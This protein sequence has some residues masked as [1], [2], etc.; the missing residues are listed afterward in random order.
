MKYDVYHQELRVGIIAWFIF[1][2]ALHRSNIHIL[3]MVRN[4]RGV[5]GD[6]HPSLL[7]DPELEETDMF[8]LLNVSLAAAIGVGG[9]AGFGR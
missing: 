3:L 8:N 2:T 7:R 5:N 6:E 4:F 9:C 1:F